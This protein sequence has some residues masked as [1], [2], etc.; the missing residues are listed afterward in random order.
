MR[1]PWNIGTD[2]VVNGK[3]NKTKYLINKKGSRAV[4]VCGK[5]WHKLPQG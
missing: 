4:A 5:L 1:K 2:S 3:R